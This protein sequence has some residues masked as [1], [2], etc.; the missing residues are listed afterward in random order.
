MLTF[1]LATLLAQPSPSRRFQV[2]QTIVVP[3]QPAPVT[4]WVPLP[5]DDA[6]QKIAVREATGGERV[7]D[8]LGNEAARYRLP[9]QG[10]TLHVAFTV[11][12][13]E[14]SGDLAAAT[15]KAGSGGNDRWLKDDKLVQVDAKI[16]ALS[17][18]VTKGAHTPL[19]KARAIYDYTVAT[20]KYQKTGDGWGN[21]SIIWACTEK[22]GNCTDFHALFMGLARAAGIPARFEI[23]RSVPAGSGEV[24]GYHCWADFWVDGAGWVPLDASEA[25][26]HPEKRGYFFGHHDDDRFALSQGRDLTLP[27][28]KGP[29]LNY[30]VNPYG[31]LPDG[32]RAKEIQ[33]TTQVTAILAAR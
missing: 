15:G 27:G 30:F 14:R 9:A 33:Q 6:W 32:S 11:E 17:A 19:E 24:Q 10:G 18:Q 16:R 8:A 21:G 23:G 20:M 12:R 7:K 3:A 28:M 22:Y 1:L 29:P 26:K 4:V 5:H 25:W 2:E 31:E 13:R